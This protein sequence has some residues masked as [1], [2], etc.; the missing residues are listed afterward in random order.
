[1]LYMH[2]HYT[3][4]GLYFLCVCHGFLD[5]A[6]KIL[7]LKSL[8]SSIDSI[9]LLYRVWRSYYLCL[10]HQSIVLKDGFRLFT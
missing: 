2:M 7:S 3:Y 5:I 9:I 4:Y 1:M 10:L 6:M 8:S